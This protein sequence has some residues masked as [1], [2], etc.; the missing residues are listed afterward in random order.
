MSA[1]AGKRIVVSGGSGFLGQRIVARLAEVQ[2]ADV[3]VPRSR[4]YDLRDR[5]AILQLLH[6]ARPDI[7]IH[8]AAVVGGIGA[9][10]A[11]P[12]RFFRCAISLMSVQFS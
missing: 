11:R 6:D 12:R 1:L 2:P 7:V 8:A 10:M 4:D 5:Q 3:V 9:N